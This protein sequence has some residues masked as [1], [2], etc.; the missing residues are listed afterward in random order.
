MARSC[1]ATVKRCASLHTTIGAATPAMPARRG[2]RV[3]QHGARAGQREQLLRIQL[4]R[5]RP[6]PRAGAARQNHRNQR[7]HWPLIAVWPPRRSLG[8][9]ADRLAA[10]DRIIAE[11]GAHH[12]QRVVEVAPVEDHRRLQRLLHVVEIRTAKF[13]PFGDDGERIGAFE[14]LGAALAQGEIRS[15][16]VDALRIPASPP[17]RRRAPWRPPPSSA[18]ISTRLGASRMSSVLGLNAQ[19][20]ER[21]GP[22]LEGAEMRLDLVEQHALLALVHRLDRGRMLGLV[23]HLV[24]RALERLARPWGSRSRRSRRPGR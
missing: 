5:Q 14:G 17:D 23:A 10:A 11:A 8:R 22:A 21:D 15:A 3:L 24:G 1:S 2:G 7:A 13:L 19:P 20:P 16:A 4:A 9:R 18:S 6:E 12:V